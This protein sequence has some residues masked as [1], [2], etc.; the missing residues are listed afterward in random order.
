MAKPKQKF[1]RGDRVK[2]ITTTHLTPV[3]TEALV[4]GSYVDLC[5]AHVSS[6]DADR[7]YTQYELM[8]LP[9]NGTHHTVAWYD[10][11]DLKRVSG[12]RGKAVLNSFL[13]VPFG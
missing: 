5:H 1:H 7:Q 4:V 3:G 2:V 13:R 10:E 12:P 9:R 8:L 6:Y 11:G